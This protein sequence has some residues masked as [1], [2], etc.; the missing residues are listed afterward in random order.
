MSN[1]LFSNYLKTLGFSTTQKGVE[2]SF[3]YNIPLDKTNTQEIS[4]PF[5]YI[6]RDNGKKLFKIHQKLWNR[7]QTNFFIVVRNNETL[8]FNAK[9]K[10]RLH[11]LDL[12]KIAAYP[13]GVSNT[14]FANHLSTLTK[15]SKNLFSNILSKENFDTGNFFRF[16]IAKRKKNRE[17]EVDKDLLL[18]LI[19]LKQDLE[20]IE[21]QEKS[22][23]EKKDSITHLLIL[24]CL[25][26]KYLEDR[27]V[28]RDKNLFKILNSGNA[29]LLINEF[30]KVKKI[31]GD[32]FKDRIFTVSE[33]QPFLSKL[34]KFFSVFD[35][36]SGQ[37]SLFPYRFDE[38]PI[39]LLSNVYEAFL[40]KSEKKSKGIFYTPTFLV[41]FILSY[42]V[43]PI[44]KNNPKASVFDPSCG[45]GAF[46]VESF[47]K[48]IK[49]QKA[50]NSFELK[51]EILTKQIFGIDIDEKAL[52]IAT[53]S[54]Y[55]DRKSVV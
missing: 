10:P 1:L 9:V 47:R 49:V 25:F 11:N 29:Q 20:I 18:N 19:A 26:L 12:G 17:N 45:S 46:L 31:N 14:F 5:Y 36:R 32:I 24:R 30:E 41:N 37:G 16:F 52:Q 2:D 42:S 51:K 13:F 4:V 22:L 55:L 3:V 7:N 15:E 8:V 28:F 33:I 35:Y 43:E 50:E 53:F 27:Q 38:I 48:I 34:G 21:L 6:K 23:N 39:Q 44:L 54:L 40:K